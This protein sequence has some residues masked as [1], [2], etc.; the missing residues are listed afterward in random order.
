MSLTNEH[1]QHR[2]TEKFGEVLT[3]FAESF[4]MLSFAAPKDHNL[5]VLQFLYDDAELKFTFLTDLTGVHYQDRK[6][7]ELAVVNQF[8]N[9]KHNLQN[10]LKIFLCQ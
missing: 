1:I 4:G 2:L 7:E 5:K 3:E 10:Q 9:L 8:H 6:N